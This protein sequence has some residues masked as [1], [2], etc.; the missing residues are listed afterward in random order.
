[1][2]DRM[3]ANNKCCK[4]ENEWSDRPIGFAK[5][6]ACPS[7]GSAYWVWTDYADPAIQSMD[8]NKLPAR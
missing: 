2:A 6:H 7:C 1:M 8:K 5:Y 3:T 4:C